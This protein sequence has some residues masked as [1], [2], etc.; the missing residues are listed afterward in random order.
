MNAYIQQLRDWLAT[1]AP[2]ERVLVLVAAVCAGIA[3]LDLALWEPLVHA[4]EKREKSLAES[5]ALAQ[6]L[7]SL[8]PDAMRARGGG[9]GANAA[10]RSMSLLAAVD[11]SA[12]SGT[13]S[14]PPTRLQPEGDDEVKVWLEA[15][16][17]DSVL[18]WINELDT[19]YG[20]TAQTIDIDKESTPGQVNVRLSLVRS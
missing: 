11:Q 7:E 13:L 6:R 14:K 10:L 18:R 5:R 12:K 1:L 4:H 16:A 8:A 20:I 2:R 19:R 9:G 15:T 17:F 3:L